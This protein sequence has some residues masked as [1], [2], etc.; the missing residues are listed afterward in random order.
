[1][2]SEDV[3]NKNPNHKTQNRESVLREGQ[4]DCAF[5]GAM[6]TLVPITDAAHLI[7]GPSG[8]INNWGNRSSLSSSS[9]LYKARFTT[10]MDENDIIFGGAKKLYNAII[11]TQRRYK[12]AAVFV[13]STCVSALIGDDLNGACTDA[14]VQTGTPIIP[15]DCPGFVGRK[16]R[17]MRIASEALLEHVIGTG[18]PDFTT[19]YDINLIGESNIAAMWNILPLFEKLGIRVLSKITGDTRYKEVCYAHRAKLNVITSS[20]A[21][22][23]MAKKMEERFGIP[24]IQESFYG[25]EN[26]NQSL[27]NIAAKL[28]D[29]DLQKRT[30][31][32]IALETSALEEKLAFYRTSVQGK[33]IVIDTQELKSWSIISAAQ[34]LGI[35]V[36]PLS[37]VKSSQEDKARIQKLLG[38][39]SIILQQNTPEEILQI[40]H[41]N[42]ADMLITGERYQH[43]SVKAEIPSLDIKAEQN[44]SNAGYAGILEAAQKLY[45][46]LTSPV[47]KLVHKPAPWE[48]R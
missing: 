37:A 38:K 18:E 10:D 24:Y 27:R 13:Y 21:L 1:M 32:F 28:G 2:K 40:I 19:P 46:T 14:A 7:H 26:I 44:H 22:L 25:I 48:N 4:E 3:F 12:P 31:K 36:I 5:D 16:N 20:I 9:M 15:V 6:L 43:T 34:K 8:C 17:G 47:W 39:D 41:E 42:K 30:E 29:S 23:K 33:R 35:E 45:A 11:E